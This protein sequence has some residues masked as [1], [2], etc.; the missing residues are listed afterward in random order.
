MNLIDIKMIRKLFNLFNYN[1]QL[2]E[3]TEWEVT[4][5]SVVLQWSKRGLV[6]NKKD[7]LLKKVFGYTTSGLFVLM[8]I[9]FSKDI[10]SYNE[11]LLIKILMLIILWGIIFFFSTSLYLAFLGGKIYYYRITIKNIEL[12]SWV[13]GIL[14]IKFFSLVFLWLVG[15]L[16]VI[17]CIVNPTLIPVNFGGIVGV[18]ILAGATLFS[19]GYIASHLDYKHLLTSWDKVTKIE[20]VEPMNIIYI[21]GTNF[22]HKKQ[23]TDLFYN[24]HNK[25]DLIAFIKQQAEHNNLSIIYSEE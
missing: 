6:D 9:F 18:G 12:A 23:N 1:Q 4:N 10:F 13:D 21:W 24:K 20:I 22:Y 5:E 7:L 15:I 19:K 16:L 17:V 25:D 14:F 11:S 2:I 8:G 3:K